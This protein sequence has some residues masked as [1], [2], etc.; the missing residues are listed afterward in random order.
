MPIVRLDMLQQFA[1]VNLLSDPGAIAGPKIAPNCVQVTLIWSLTDGKEGRNVLTARYAPPFLGTVTMANALLAAFGASLTSRGVD[2]FQP[3]TG[4]LSAVHLRDI[5]IAFQP[6]IEST[7]PAHAGTS[8]STALPDETAIVLTLRTGQ[9]GPANRGR[10]Y[11]PSWASNAVAA[12]G[13]IAEAV[14][15]ALNPWAVDITAALA[16]EGLQ[17]AIAQ[18]AR[19]A[20]TGSTGREHPARAAASALVTQAI[21]RDN[22]WDTQRRRGL[23]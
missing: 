9:T 2:V 21:T 14:L 12:G 19:Q 11:V 20:Y 22:H 4:A 5:N 8:I 1:A 23:K 15:E 17:W 16:A 7:G 10:M 3:I 18:P 13:V 6:I